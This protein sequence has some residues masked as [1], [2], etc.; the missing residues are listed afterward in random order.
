MQTY[1]HK[2]SPAGSYNPGVRGNIQIDTFQLAESVKCPKGEHSD[3]HSANMRSNPIGISTPKARER[4]LCCHGL[5]SHLL[6]LQRVKVDCGA[7]WILP[8]T[9]CIFHEEPANR[10]PPY[11][12]WRRRS[13][14]DSN[15]HRLQCLQR[16]SQ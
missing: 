9:L 11:A 13:N 4:L 15:Y 1:N 5:P 8:S 2:L 14:V 3:G 7:W 10:P 12:S 6:L 16:R